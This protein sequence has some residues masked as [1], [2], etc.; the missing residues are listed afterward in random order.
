MEIL[1]K[2]YRSLIR[3][4]QHLPEN[5]AIPA[6]YLLSGCIPVAGLVHIK[7]MTFLGEIARSQPSSIA[8]II[9][10][11]IAIKDLSSNSWVTQI[12]KILHK[13]NLPPPF[14]VFQDRP[15]KSEWK[16]K[17][18]KVVRDFWQE[19]LVSKAET[20]PSLVYLDIENCCPGRIHD[21]WSHNSTVLDVY[22]ATVKAR[23]LVK[24]Y[25]LAASSY[26]GRNKPNECNLCKDGDE[27][28]PHF[29][30]E[31]KALE[32]ERTKH[33]S[34]MITLAE[35]LGLSTTHDSL[36]KLI[37]TPRVMLGTSDVEI[38][39]RMSRDLIFALHNKRCSLLGGENQYKKV[40]KVKS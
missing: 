26:A 2:Y 6:I 23:L 38:L 28:T 7:M 21:V 37:L 30:L 12:R 14:E 24:R 34:R 3:Q 36:M 13:Y 11:Q 40:V 25:P 4:I 31:C 18:K 17:V 9:Q 32:A 35:S 15:G 5:T 16:H 20:M 1:E 27:T 29:L 33:L 19:S 8:D 10:R 22:R 39:E